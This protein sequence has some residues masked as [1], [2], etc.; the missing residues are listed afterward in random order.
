MRAINY[1]YTRLMDTAN[2]YV[3]FFPPRERS[4]GIR[5]IT[6]RLDVGIIGATGIVRSIDRSDAAA[7]NRHLETRPRERRSRLGRSSSAIGFDEI[8][9][10]R[11]AR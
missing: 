7:K 10:I 3:F 5:R 2:G 6:L 8:V 9:V 11:S 1:S 4:G